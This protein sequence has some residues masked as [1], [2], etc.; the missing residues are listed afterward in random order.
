VWSPTDLS[1]NLGLLSYPRQYSILAAAEE[2]YQ[3][4]SVICKLIDY[5]DV[6]HIPPPIFSVS[7]LPSSAALVVGGSKTVEVQ[8]KSN[9]SLASNVSLSADQ[10]PMLR[11]AF[12]P[13]N[14]F[15]PPNGMSCTQLQIWALDNATPSQYS[16][17]IMANLT[18]P[19]ES[20]N[21]LTGDELNNTGIAG[22]PIEDANFSVAV[23]PKPTPT[24]SQSISSIASP[25]QGGFYVLYG[26]M[27]TAVAGW[28]VPAIA[29][30]LNTETKIVCY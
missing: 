23:I 21:W 3:M 1:L 20:K 30:F 24:V 28:S 5:T 11:L 7:T 19:L 27:A 18:F 29:A 15:L 9:T 8:I 4:D 25:L 16:M 13:S 6:I 12:K 26:I 2:V 17:P 14:F 10:N 22:V